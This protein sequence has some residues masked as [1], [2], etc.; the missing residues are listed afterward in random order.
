[1]KE[2]L[3]T[4]AELVTPGNLADAA[5]AYCCRY[6]K[7][8]DEAWR[9]GRLRAVQRSAA[10][11]ASALEEFRLRGSVHLRGEHSSPGLDAEAEALYG[12]LTRW[13]SSV[14]AA[15]E[16]HRRCICNSGEHD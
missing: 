15:A 1:M 2:W 3:V 14:K 12:A 11:L 8:E 7:A 16:A 9:R 6:G 4:P 10:A 5:S 13:S